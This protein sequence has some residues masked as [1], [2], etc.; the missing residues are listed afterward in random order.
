MSFKFIRKLLTGTINGGG[1][2]RRQ[3][4]GENSAC[5]IITN[6][7]TFGEKMLLNSSRCLTTSSITFILYSNPNLNNYFHF[8]K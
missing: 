5:T 3:F 1:C 7:K 6:T 2:E 8:C 4:T